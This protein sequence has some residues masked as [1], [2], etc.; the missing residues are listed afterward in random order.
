MKTN[1]KFLLIASTLALFLNCKNNSE[2][3]EDTTSPTVETQT[4]NK[5]GQAFITDDESTPNVLQIA[6]GSKDHSTLVAAVQAA[7]LENALVNA[8]PL[9]VFA[10]LKT[11]KQRSISTY[12][13]ASCY[14]W[15]LFKR[16]FKEI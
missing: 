6:I 12:F 7:Q 9:M 16:L 14:T 11:R 5:Q 13:K 3:Q 4:D 10:P 8:G 1:H 15:E 2:G